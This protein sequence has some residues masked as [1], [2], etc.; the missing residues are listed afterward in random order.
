MASIT[1]VSI[2]DNSVQLIFLL[3]IFLIFF[4]VLLVTRCVCLMIIVKKN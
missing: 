1:K 2:D 3:S 4:P